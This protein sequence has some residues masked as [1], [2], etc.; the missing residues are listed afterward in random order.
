MGKCERV[1]GGGGSEIF[2]FCTSVKEALKQDH[3]RLSAPADSLGHQ[4]SSL[5]TLVGLQLFHCGIS[6]P[7]CLSVEEAGT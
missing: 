7:V 4:C 1:G 2:F 3:S 6:N 5:V